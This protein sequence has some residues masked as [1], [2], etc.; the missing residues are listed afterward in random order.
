MGLVLRPFDEATRI[1]AIGVGTL[2]EGVARSRTLQH[3]LATVAILD[4][5]AVDVHGEQPAFCV[6]QDVALATADL[7]AGVVTFRAPL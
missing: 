7:L 6:G 3:A 2:Y 4:V 1:T 5:G